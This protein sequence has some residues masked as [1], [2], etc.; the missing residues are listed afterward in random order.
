LI[1]FDK[2][3][4]LNF[5]E[6]IT[7]FFVLFYY[8][9]VVIIGTGEINFVNK[10]I[11]PI[12]TLFLFYYLISN[13]YHEKLKSK[14]LTKLVSILWLTVLYFNYSI[15]INY[16]DL[17]IG[18]FLGDLTVIVCLLISIIIG[19]KI[20]IFKNIHNYFD[21]LVFIIFSLLL[22][23]FFFNYES[24]AGQLRMYSRLIFVPSYFL[25]KF[26][27][28]QKSIYFYLFVACLILSIF[29]NMRYA[30]IVTV[31]YLLLYTFLFSKDFFINLFKRK[32]ILFLF[33][34]ILFFSFFTENP[35]F[36]RW[37]F[38]D[39]FSTDINTSQLGL[40]TTFSSRYFEV[41]DTFSHIIN[42]FN[43]LTILFGNG[44]GAAFKAELFWIWADND[45]Y[46]VSDSFTSQSHK[47][48]IHFG[49]VRIFFRYGILGLLIVGFFL[50]DLIKYIKNNYHLN[51]LSLA[52]AITLCAL[53]LRLFIQP[54]FNDL[55]ISIL[56]IAFYN[57]QRIE[58]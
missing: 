32:G 15:I 24:E 37:R 55:I 26:F 50:T 33:T 38:F 12:Y 4:L 28:L 54:V 10:L 14:D 22:L 40:I 57:L 6:K 49:P 45:Y 31:F 23:D 58:K 27:K 42:T 51:T 16:S 1:K 11:F 8:G 30:F 5:F 56:I 39:L 44:A 47:H 7:S 20:N 21:I 13:Y 35:F 46:N 52:I 2:Y 53:S 34:A 18:W 36:A 17:N 25:Y 3:Y 19:K 9:S 29:T 48:I 43:P 41:I